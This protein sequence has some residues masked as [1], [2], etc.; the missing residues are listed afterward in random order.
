M[1]IEQILK[2]NICNKYFI[3]VL[4]MQL[5]IMAFVRHIMLLLSDA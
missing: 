3:R 5:S 1:G 4:A 2:K